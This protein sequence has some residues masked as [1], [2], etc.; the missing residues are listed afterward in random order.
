MSLK[1]K[2]II[3][4]EEMLVNYL[5]CK[6][7]RI[8]YVQIQQLIGSNYESTAKIWVEGFLLVF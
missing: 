6:V 5:V 1:E 4:G 8:D 3:H 2:S 7:I